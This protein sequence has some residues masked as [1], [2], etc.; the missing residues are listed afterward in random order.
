[1]DLTLGRLR[2]GAIY[3]RALGLGD[4]VMP[5]SLAEAHVAVVLDSAI[6]VSGPPAVLTD[7]A[8]LARSVPSVAVLTRSQY[9]QAVRAAAQASTWPIW[10]LIGLIVAFAALALLNTALM[11]TAG[12]Q[13]ELALI[14]LIGAPRRQAR[15]MIAWEALV[16]TVAGLVV[17]ALI[18]RIAVQTPRGQPGWHIAIPTVLSAAIFS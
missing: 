1:A 16:T 5:L 9:L 17:G 12:R 15:R 4:I 7:S 8:R 6:F 3:Q 10:L 14:R 2:V 18:A 11:A 13:R